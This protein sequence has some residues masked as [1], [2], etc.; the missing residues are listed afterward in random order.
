MK[1][2]KVCLASKPHMYADGKDGVGSRILYFQSNLRY[3]AGGGRIIESGP[4]TSWWKSRSAP[5]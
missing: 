4:W 3:D 1:W 2:E 5:E